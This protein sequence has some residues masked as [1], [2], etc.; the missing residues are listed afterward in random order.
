MKTR[1]ITATLL[2]VLMGCTQ[3]KEC[4]TCKT[5][6]K[7]DYSAGMPDG[8]SSITEQICDGDGVDIDAYKKARTSKSTTTATANGYKVTLVTT[9]TCNCTPQ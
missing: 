2:T 9:S 4:F 7:M 8:T 5:T 1:L 6:V 3:E